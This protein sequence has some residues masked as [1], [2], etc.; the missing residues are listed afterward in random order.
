MRAF[1]QGVKAKRGFPKLFLHCLRSGANP[2][3]IYPISGARPPET[4]LPRS[5]PCKLPFHSEHHQSTTRRAAPDLL[6]QIRSNAVGQV[7]PTTRILR[8]LRLVSIQLFGEGRLSKFASNDHRSSNHGPV[9][10]YIYAPQACQTTRHA[11]S[12]TRLE[13]DEKLPEDDSFPEC[14]ISVG[15][16]AFSK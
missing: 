16:A 10:V 5:A 1:P 6:S 9:S 7:K 4:N 12:Q 3:R 11:R 15:G 2:L 14:W 8:H 13:N